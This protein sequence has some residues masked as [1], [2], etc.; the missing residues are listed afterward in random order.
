[1]SHPTLSKGPKAPKRVP[2][3]FS[4]GFHD[5]KELDVWFRYFEERRIPVG[6]VSK[7][8][9][10]RFTLWRVG[11]DAHGPTTT[12]RIT[13]GMRVERSANGFEEAFNKRKEEVIGGKERAKGGG[14]PGLRQQEVHA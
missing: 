4:R 9:H 10:P 7:S 3:L 1:M 8:Q 11:V 14:A 6:I 13:E 2:Y 5:P 12:P